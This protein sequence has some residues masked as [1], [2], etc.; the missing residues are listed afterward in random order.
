MFSGAI[1]IKREYIVRILKFEPTQTLGDART[2]L[3]TVLVSWNLQV[4][5]EHNLL[6]Q[7]S[8]SSKNFK[9]GVR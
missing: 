2:E 9:G 1:L 5:R 6:F 8:K 3:S 7:F 4:R